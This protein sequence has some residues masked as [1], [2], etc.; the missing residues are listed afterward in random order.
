MST[1]AYSY[2]LTNVDK[3]VSPMEMK[4][5]NQMRLLAVCL[6]V[7]G[8]LCACNS[9]KQ[10]QPVYSSVIE[11]VY[12]QPTDSIIPDSISSLIHELATDAN[13]YQWN[14]HAVLYGV[15]QNMG[16]MKEAIEQMIP[17]VTVRLYEQPFYIFDRA[18]DCDANDIAPEWEHTLMTANLV[19]DTTLQREYMDYHAT[20]TEKFPEVK[21]GFCKAEFQQLL[22]FRNGRQL[23]LVISIPKGKTLAELDPKTVENNPRVV[24]WNSI[25][26]KYQEGIE[27]TK[28]G[29]T[30]VL[31]N[32]MK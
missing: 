20:Q 9:P 28:P 7:V 27:G 19:A 18:L 23:M 13:V 16:A 26:G 22:V 4:M 24:E 32:T 3:S 8:F 21:Y 11:I 29:E 2:R 1:K 30:W 6:L 12:G 31:F 15:F 14:N 5:K 10:P 25:M 17:D